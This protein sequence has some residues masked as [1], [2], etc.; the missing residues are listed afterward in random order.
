MRTSAETVA[1]VESSPTR[2]PVESV[3]VAA[4]Q[5]V[6]AVRPAATPTAPVALPTPPPKPRSIQ[7]LDLLEQDSPLKGRLR[8]SAEGLPV[9]LLDPTERTWFSTS[10]LKGLAGWALRELSAADVHHADEKEFIT[11]IGAVQ[12]HPYARLQWLAHLVRDEG[13]LNASLDPGARYKLA[14]WPQSEREFPRHF[15]IATVMLKQSGTPGEIAELAGATAGDVANF[16]NAYH[17]LGYIDQES[18]ERVAEPSARG[19]LFGRIRKASANI[20]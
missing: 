20:S 2:P 14:R 19:G 4:A 6:L 13:Q 15:R 8:L 7:L 16:I 5:P 18:T 9:I 11:E 3:V 10:G 17:A 12:G 1:P